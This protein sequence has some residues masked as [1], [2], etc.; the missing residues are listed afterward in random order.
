MKRYTFDGRV[1]DYSELTHQHLSNIIWFDKIFFNRVDDFNMSQLYERFGGKILPY[2]PQQAFK[3]EIA[4]LE[5]K[6]MLVPGL[7][8]MTFIM[9][10]GQIIG[11]IWNEVPNFTNIIGAQP[12]RLVGFTRLDVPEIG[13]RVVFM[14]NRKLNKEFHPWHEWAKLVKG[15]TYEIQDFASDANGDTW[16]EVNNQIHPIE[17]FARWIQDDRMSLAEFFT[18]IMMPEPW[19]LLGL[20]DYPNEDE[21]NDIDKW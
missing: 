21:L 1:L 8:G 6:G 14:V 7:N 12:Y 11:N 9:Y 2:Q 5:L 10:E 19:V 18:K 20:E 4:R 16:I 15:T 13:D 17:K 3:E